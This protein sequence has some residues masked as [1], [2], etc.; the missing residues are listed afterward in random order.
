MI[1]PA[2]ILLILQSDSQHSFF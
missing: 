2:T 1:L